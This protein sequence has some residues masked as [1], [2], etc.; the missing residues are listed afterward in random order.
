MNG[1]PGDGNAL[2]L[3][4]DVVARSRAPRGCNR[5]EEPSAA[6]VQAIR[7]AFQSAFKAPVRIGIIA[8]DSEDRNRH[9]T[10]EGAS[11]LAIYHLELVVTGAHP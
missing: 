6:Q 3:H 2:S 1:E 8:A 7:L 4:L 10:R 5:Q 9:R 11:A